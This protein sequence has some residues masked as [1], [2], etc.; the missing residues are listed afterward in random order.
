MRRSGVQ[1]TLTVPHTLEKGYIGVHLCLCFLLTCGYVHF[2]QF[3][4]AK[5]DQFVPIAAFKQDGSFAIA[6]SLHQSLKPVVSILRVNHA[7]G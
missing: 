7:N 3:R 2:F 1:S 4:Q 6:D 5:S